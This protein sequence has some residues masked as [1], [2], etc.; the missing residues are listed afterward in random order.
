[1][2]PEKYIVGCLIIVAGGIAATI[3]TMKSPKKRSEMDA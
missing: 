2:H 3:V 1:M